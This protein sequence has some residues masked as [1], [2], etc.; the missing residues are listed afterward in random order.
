MIWISRQ[1][2]WV[3][4]MYIS[5]AVFGLAGIFFTVKATTKALGADSAQWRG[6]LFGIP[7]TGCFWLCCLIGV[8]YGWLGFHHWRESRRVLKDFGSPERQ[9]MSAL[10]RI[11]ENHPLVYGST[12]TMILT[13]IA[14]ITAVILLKEP[15]WLGITFM[16]VAIRWWLWIR[17]TTPP[18]ILFLSCSDPG[19][20]D[21]H[22]QLKRLVSP[23]RVVTLLD[24]ENCPSTKTAEELSLDCLRTGNSDDWKKVIYILIDMAPVVIMNADTDTAGVHE[25]AI[26]VPKNMLM[27]KTAFLKKGDARLLRLQPE[28]AASASNCF[29]VSAT[30]LREVLIKILDSVE[31]PTIDHDIRTFAGQSAEK[32]ET[33]HLL[34]DNA[35]CCRCKVAMTIFLGVNRAGSF[36]RKIFVHPSHRGSF[37]CAA[38]GRYY[39]WNCSDSRKPCICGVQSWQERQ[40]FPAG[41]SP[42]QALK[43]L[44]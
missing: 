20:I 5:L 39:C 21:A 8:F 10:C 29:V 15:R 14:S 31:L 42:K 32:T 2:W 37:R 24:L 4:G 9:V 16:V 25:E 41:V 13:A 1:R 44:V 34:L 26:Y 40:Y 23:L 11:S 19:S 18:F 27:F 38:C 30:K 6:C 36:P 35:A 33:G 28:P 7:L 17:V 43:G 3:T 22:K 12:T